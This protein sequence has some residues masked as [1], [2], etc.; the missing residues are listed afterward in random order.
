MP[1][2]GSRTAPQPHNRRIAP[3]TSFLPAARPISPYHA[4]PMRDDTLE[5]NGQDD[6]SLP[7]ARAKS[8]QHVRIDGAQRTMHNL[9]HDLKT[10]QY[11]HPLSPLS[12]CPLA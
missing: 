6:T 8:Q 5:R 11:M 10:L 3:S 4:A 9:Q 1:A 7:E 12:S 2:V